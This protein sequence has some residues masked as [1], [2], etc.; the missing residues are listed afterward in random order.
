M[1]TPVPSSSP[2]WYSAGSALFADMLAAINAA[3]TSLA[4]EM[5][6]Y[7]DGHPGE[8]IRDALVRARERGVRVRVLLD[9]IGSFELPGD[10]WSPLT[11]T[12]GE[13]RFFNPITLKRFA[14]RDHRKLLV[15]D[16]SEAFI[17]GFN[18]APDYDGD[19]VS[20]GWRDFGLR[21]T[22]AIVGQIAESFELMF[23]RADFQHQRF[24]QFRKP[25]SNRS[26]PGTNTRLL[27]SGPGRGANPFIRELRADLATAREVKIV[28]AYFLPNR[29]LQRELLKVRR[30]GGSV[31]LV[32]PGRS[33][34]PLSQFAA[35][36]LYRRLTRRGVEIFEYQPQILHGKL[37]IVDGKV[38]VGSANLD[39]RS[40]HINYEL[41]VR[42]EDPTEAAHARRLFQETLHHSRRVE[43]GEHTDGLRDRIGQ[44]LAFWL[45]V[46]LD[47]WLA[48]F[49]LRH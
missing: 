37:L 42:V 30:R 26:L 22:G 24:L 5:Y 8:A 25:R 18:V 46:R 12:G 21:V 34:V 1:E 45:L 13:V 35:R 27:L 39:P 44:R 3:R 40:L 31:Q 2:R 9:A 11:E 38:Y 48:R 19:G 4:L 7:A 43:L 28:M 20:R 41:M 10:F 33:D 47:P 14:I 32:L 15:C 16:H 17:G 23:D 36:G 6:I 49:Q 29:R